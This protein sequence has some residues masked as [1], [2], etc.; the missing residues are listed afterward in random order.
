MAGVLSLVFVGWEIRQNTTAIRGST[1]QAVADANMEWLMFLLENPE[2]AH[3]VQRWASGDTT[4][5]EPEVVRARL[6]ILTFW[7]TIEN[8]HYQYL[9]GNLPEEAVRRW[10]RP[11]VFNN[12][13]LRDW[14]QG[15]R[16]QF[17]PVFQAYVDSLTESAAD[18]PDSG[19]GFVP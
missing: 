15:S 17:T 14:W 8:A 9:Q 18:Q 1:Y 3:L 4:M 19:R 5:S 2:T 12:P 10:V 7:R 16:H 11:E 6:G 13:V